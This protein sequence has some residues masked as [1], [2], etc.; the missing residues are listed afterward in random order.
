LEPVV[1]AVV[2][3]CS[4]DMWSPH[5]QLPPNDE[6]WSEPVVETDSGAPWTPAYGRG[7]DEWMVAVGVMLI[8]DPLVVSCRG[9]RSG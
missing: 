8:V 4:I 1:L 2:G 5:T 7:E 6:P 3:L 9:R